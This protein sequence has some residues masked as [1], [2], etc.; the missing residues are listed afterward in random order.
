M[1]EE[2]AQTFGL[3]GEA[4]DLLTELPADS[5]VAMAQTDFGKLLDFYIDAVADVVGGRDTIERQLQAA[6]GLDL[7]RDVIAWMGDFGVFV[8][9]TSVAELDGALIIE[10]TDEAASGRL[11]EAL[12]RL[13]TTQAQGAVRI[14]PLSAPG[15]G[16][17]FTVSSGAIPK[18]IHVFQRD[19]RVVFAYGDTAASDAVDAG[20]KL[21][22]RPGLRG[23]AG[24]ARRLRRVVLHP[25]FSRSSTSS[26]STERP[27][28]RTG[29]RPSRT[30][31]R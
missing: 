22:D 25:G 21:G 7:E 2:L 17:G 6:T 30:S 19:G 26:S 3:G 18:P 1:P 24:R 9:G 20:S 11:L 5:W 31:S 28:T 15:G 29:R 4:S 27:T 12:G 16:E 10:T 13:V 23:H 8:R 14:G